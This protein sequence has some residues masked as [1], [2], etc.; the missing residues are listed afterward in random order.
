MLY[1]YEIINRDALLASLLDGVRASGNR[2]VHV[3]MTSTDKGLRVGPL[4]LPVE[5]EVES[6]HIKFLQNPPPK[7]TFY[8]CV[9]RFNANVPYSGLLYSITQ[10]VSIPAFYFNFTCIM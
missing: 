6:I 5:E 10:E 1:F 4:Y 2:N 9:R 7:R 8:E 3:T